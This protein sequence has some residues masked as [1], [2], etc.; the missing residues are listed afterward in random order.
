MHWL[1]LGKAAKYQVSYVV[2]R[3]LLCVLLGPFCFAVCLA[4]PIRYFYCFSA[5]FALLPV[6]SEHFVFL[7]CRLHPVGGYE[8]AVVFVTTYS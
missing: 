8:F 7:P 2:W 4:C 5:C 6:I 1:V 3:F